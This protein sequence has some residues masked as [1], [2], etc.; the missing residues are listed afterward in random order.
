MITRE[1][2]AG[3][4]RGRPCLKTSKMKTGHGNQNVEGTHP[5]R[6][7]VGCH[8]PRM[9]KATAGKGRL[10]TADEGNPQEGVSKDKVKDEFSMKINKIS[11]GQTIS[12]VITGGFAY[13]ASLKGSHTVQI[14]RL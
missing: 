6:Q 3:E 2:E 1:A 5:L 4:A 9:E 7:L 12:L 8:Y 11:S 10:G 13:K 14:L